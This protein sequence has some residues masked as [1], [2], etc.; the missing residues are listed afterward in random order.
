MIGRIRAALLVAAMLACAAGNAGAERRMGFQP[1]VTG[2]ISVSWFTGDLAKVAGKAQLGYEVGTFLPVPLGGRF[3]LRPGIAFTTKGAE[4]HG[5]YVVPVLD[6]N[7]LVTR[8]Q[9]YPVD[10]NMNL[11]YIEAPVLVR[12]RLS[13]VGKHGWRAT[14]GLAPGVRVGASPSHIMSSI[15]TSLYPSGARRFE[16]SGV[17]GL[18]FEWVRA[19]AVSFVELR[20][21]YGLTDV[22]AGDDGPAGRNAAVMLAGGAHLR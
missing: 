2:G 10:W 18:G 12:A 4:A 6:E 3:E 15:G 20:M 16:L 22:F 7:F 13:G 8:Y 5:E 17:G 9:R 11:A 19:K 14:L 1:P 21:K